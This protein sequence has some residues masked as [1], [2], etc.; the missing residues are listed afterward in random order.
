MCSGAREG[1]RAR[2][3]ERVCSTR[4]REQ[5][6]ARARESEGERARESERAREREGERA[7]GRE[8]ERGA[9]PVTPEFR[10]GP[11]LND[12]PWV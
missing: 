3:S 8:S 12:P 9:G 5:E 11:P 1:E 7:R 4:E 10:Y 6:S 2:E